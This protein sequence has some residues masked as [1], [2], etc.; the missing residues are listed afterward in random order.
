MGLLGRD[1]KPGEGAT[2]IIGP[3][4]RIK[5]DLESAGSVR[6]DGRVDGTI[7]AGKGVAIGSSGE[8]FGD[9][10]T[11]DALVGGHVHG[12]VVAEG[13]L[14]LQRTAVVEGEIRTRAE[15][16]KIE[17]GARFNGRIS[18]PEEIAAVA[19]PAQALLPPGA[20]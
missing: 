14:E 18:M 19:E 8:V 6:V 5:G 3:G 1:R 16:L 12:T 10:I 17:E 9:V 11:Q 13:R 20:S 4:T 7:R 2:S 15:H